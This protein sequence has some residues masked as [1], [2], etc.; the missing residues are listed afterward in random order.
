[1]PEITLSSPA[2]TVFLSVVSSVATVGLL[3]L[4]SWEYTRPSLPSSSGLMLEQTTKSTTTRSPYY[5]YYYGHSD[6]ARF[7]SW[8]GRKGF[9]KGRSCG[10]IPRVLIFTWTTEDTYTLLEN[11][12]YWKACYAHAHGF[13]LV[14]TDEGHLNNVSYYSEA[15]MFGWVL[16]I[17]KYLLAG[18]YDYV[19]LMGGDVLI[20]AV[21]LDFPLWAYND[22][23]YLSIMD[24]GYSPLGFNENDL[25][26]RVSSA[27]SVA[28]SEQFVTMMFSHR[29][30]HS[31]QGDNGPYMENLLILLGREAES[32]GFHGY[33]NICNESLVKDRSVRQF[34]H[35][36]GWQ[37]VGEWNLNYSNCFFKQLDMLAGPWNKRTSRQIGFVSWND[38]TLPLA[39]C[40]TSVWQVNRTERCFAFHWNGGTG[41]EDGAHPATG[42]C[43]DPTFN[44][45]ASLY[46]R[47][48][49]G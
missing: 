15:N 8:S 17:K 13:D 14:I 35:D 4:G 25:L 27:E 6:C 45:S 28:W 11:E 44:W 5:H 23:H 22:G 33:D 37:A 21:N 46:N 43:P 48:N 40:W 1:M 20:N 12:V 2:V 10:N 9:L 24:Q 3:W 49:R 38:K 26:F 16:P 42:G 34:I 41:R 19:F 30:R 39:N 7:Q 47:R 32:K 36:F 31:L 29:V 18:V